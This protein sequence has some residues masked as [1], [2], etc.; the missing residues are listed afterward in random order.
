MPGARGS[1]TMPLFRSCP[2]APTMETGGTDGS[3]VRSAGIPAT[4]GPIKMEQCAALTPLHLWYSL[5]H[6]WKQSMFG[7]FVKQIR[8]CQRLGLREFCLENGYDPSNWSKIEREVLPPPRD[9]DTLRAGQGA[10]PQTRFRR[11]AQ[12]LRLRRG[13]FRADSRLRP[14]R[15]RACRATPRL[16]P[17][18]L[19][20]ETLARGLGKTAWNSSEAPTN[21]ERPAQIQSAIQSQRTYLAGGRP[22]ARRISGRTR[23]AR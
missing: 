10:P 5:Y 17:Y 1:T 9:E 8:E 18:H 3:C 6:N 2:V 23:I 12:V 22:V 16:L 7:Q 19:R 11:L 4:Q 15:R 20:P 13:G 14:Q 21:L